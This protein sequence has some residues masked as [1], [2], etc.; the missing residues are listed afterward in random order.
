MIYSFKHVLE[1]T[2]V[3]WKD[4]EEVEIEA[5]SLGRSFMTNHIK[6]KDTY[7]KYSSELYITDSLQMRNYSKW[8]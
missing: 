8:A 5:I 4:N 6:Y 2:I 3:K 1:N 7:L